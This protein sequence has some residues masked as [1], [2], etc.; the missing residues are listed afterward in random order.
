MRQFGNDAINRR[1][2]KPKSTFFYLQDFI[3]AKNIT[4]LEGRFISSEYR[5]DEEK[6]VPII[7]GKYPKGS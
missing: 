3:T 1:A 7:S 2:S 6:G 4:D 5:F